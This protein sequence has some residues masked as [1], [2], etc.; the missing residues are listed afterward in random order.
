MADSNK[1][2][3]KL[4]KYFENPYDL[5]VASARTCYSPRVVSDEEINEGQRK[6]IGKGCFEAGHHTVFQ[7]AMF[8]FSIENVSRHFVWAFLHSHP[9]YN[10]DQ[11]SQRYVKLDEV[12]ATAPPLKGENLELYN[13]TVEKAWK[14]YNKLTELLIPVIKKLDN[15]KDDKLIEKKAIELARYVIPVSAQTSLTH[16]IN[17]LTLFRLYK[18]MNQYPV[19]FEAREVISEMVSEVEK[20]DPEF[21]RDLDDSVPLEKTLEYQ[22]IQNFKPKPEKF[23]SEFDSELGNYSSKLVD[24]TPNSEKIMAD[25]VRAVL[26]SPDLS[27]EEAID[28]VLNPKKNDYLLSMLNLSTMSPLMRT[29]NHPYF[30]FKK[31]ISHT[32][33]S[34]DQRHR[35]VP[36]SRPVLIFHDSKK[37]DYVTPKLIENNSEIKKVYDAYMSEVWKAKNKL[38]ENGAKVEYAQ[39]LLPNAVSI[40]M[41]ESGNYLNLWHKW[42]LRTCLNSQREIWEASLEEIE[43]VSEHFPNLTKHVG[44]ECKFRYKAGVKP[45]CLEG[46]RTCGWPVWM[47]DNIKKD[48]RKV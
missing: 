43:Q 18:L 4:Q 28:S 19:Q 37:P 36:A 21:F 40:R 23:I 27:D 5:S 1:P 41:V 10:T 48:K 45:F 16:T 31:K 32:A 9:F 20:K 39:Y 3:I 22:M 35:T 12:K 26:A 33:D 6:R 17:G 7:H 34:Q 2:K 38:I 42:R 29:M 14:V 24:Y 11:S 47:W 8:N 15:K 44:P 46:S 25:S 13:K 30:V